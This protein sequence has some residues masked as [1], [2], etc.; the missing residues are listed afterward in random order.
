ML[1][2]RVSGELSHLE[3][4]VCMYVTLGDPFQVC[5]FQNHAIKE[6]TPCTKAFANRMKKADGGLPCRRGCQ[7]IPDTSHSSRPV[8]CQITVCDSKPSQ[9]E[10][11]IHGL[12]LKYSQPANLKSWFVR[13]SNHGLSPCAIL[14][15][16]SEKKH[17]KKKTRK[18]NFHGIVLGFWGGFC[19][20]VF[21]SAIRNDPKKTHKQNFGTRP[22]PGQSRKCVYVYVFF[23]PPKIMVCLLAQI[24]N[25]GLPKHTFWD[26]CGRA[27]E[28]FSA[29]AIAMHK[30]DPQPSLSNNLKEF[31]SFVMQGK[32]GYRA[33]LHPATRKIP[34]FQ[35]HHAGESD[36]LRMDFLSANVHDKVRRL[37]GW[38]WRMILNYG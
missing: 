19:L 14:K 4:R 35:T 7:K 23:L 22:V 29:S 6:A 8:T 16:G 1:V 38:G 10:R 27:A 21:F 28:F 36:F 9:Q 15:S 37:V 13:S 18:Q 17:I 30:W 11:S 2:L 32:Q 24:P 33:E 31:A 3:L 26:R 20:C 34:Y 5:L 25:H 12:S